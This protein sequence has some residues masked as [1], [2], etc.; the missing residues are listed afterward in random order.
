MCASG[1]LAVHSVE[2][3]ALG[4]RQHSVPGLGRH[5]GKPG[6]KFPLLR[7]PVARGNYIGPGLRRNDG[8][9]IATK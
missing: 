6:P 9:N 1:L 2:V 5:T 8:K 3:M 7:I 4:C